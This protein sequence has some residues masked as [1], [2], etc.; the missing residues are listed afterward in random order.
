M[1]NNNEIKRT[2]VDLGNYNIKYTG[3]GGSGMFS[4]KISTDYQSFPEGFQ[5]IEIDNGMNTSYIGIGSLSR[6]FN[7]ADR[8]YIP[9]LLYA[10]CK[11][12]K[13]DT[14]ETSLAL[15][16]PI[17]QMENKSKLL[18]TLKDKTFDFRYNGQDRIV[19]IKNVLVLP[20]GYVS[21]FALSDKDRQGSICLL[22]M[23]SRTVNLCVLEN[24]KIQKLNTIKL[25]SFDFY[26][27][28]KNQENAKGNDYQEEDIP[29]LIQ[30]GIIKVFQKQYN[31]FLDQL[32]NAVK[33]YVNIKTYNTIFTGGTSLLLKDSIEKLN[34]PKYKIMDNALNSNVLGAKAAAEMIWRAAENVQ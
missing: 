24:G 25:G 28:I 23:G 5:R 10:I 27:Q 21:E 34:L 12:N 32:L 1:E 30:D 31:D 11:A 13:E 15:L 2:Y 22:D 6:E 3:A 20:E 7:K 4:S 9:Q 16:L 8:E 18:D 19:S 14:I 33:P 26:S 29:R 17:I